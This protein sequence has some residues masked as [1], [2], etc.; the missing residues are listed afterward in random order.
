VPALN[1]PGSIAAA[2]ERMA[3]ERAQRKAPAGEAA[4]RRGLLRY[5]TVVYCTALRTVL[6]NTEVAAEVPVGLV[7][8]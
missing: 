1:S 2:A 7:D 6:Y 5:S 3:Q 8:C 4:G